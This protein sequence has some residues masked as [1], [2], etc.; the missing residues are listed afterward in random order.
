MKKSYFVISALILSAGILSFQHITNYSEISK[1]KKIHSSGESGA[2]SGSPLDAQCTSCHNGNAQVGTT[3]NTLNLLSGSTIETSYTPGSVYQME[4]IMNPNPTKKGFQAVALTSTN[5][6]AGTFSTFSGGGAQIFSSKRATHTGTSNTS[7]N[8]SWKWTWNAPATN[9]GTI[10]FYVA[11]IKANNNGSD[12]SGDIVYLSQHTFAA[13]TG[14]GVNEVKTTDYNFSAG[15][16]TEKNKVYIDFN[17][18]IIGKMNFNLVDLNGRSVFTYEMGESQIGENNASVTLPEELKN[19]IYIVN[20][21][22]NN[23]GMEQKI[24]IQK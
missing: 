19:G 1:F 24:M 16:S 9:V 22:L 6:Y 17:S 13:A 18:K 10:T 2:Y 3:I 7:A 15:Y 5:A 8:S 4:L 14:L 23:N 20:F 11:T 12:G 21:F